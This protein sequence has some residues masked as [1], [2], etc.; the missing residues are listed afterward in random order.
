VKS[1]EDLRGRRL[2]VHASHTAP[3]CFARIVLRKHGLDPDRDLHCAS[4]VPGDYQ[5]D[6]RRLPDGS[7]A[8]A[9]V[10]STLSVDAVAAEVGVAS[11]S[12]D[13]VYQA[14]S[15]KEM[16]S[17]GPGSRRGKSAV[18]HSHYVEACHRRPGSVSGRCVR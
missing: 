14:G 10:G 15:V 9:H 4:R 16:K 18:L 6:L 7:I 8:A 17:P 5:T 12:A 2:A 13:R 1:T 3:G 11:V